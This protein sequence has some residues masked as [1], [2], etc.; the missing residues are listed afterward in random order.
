M[1]RKKVFG[2]ILLLIT[3]FF[4]GLFGAYTFEKIY[5]KEKIIEVPVYQGYTSEIAEKSAPREINGDFVEASKKSSPA[6]VFI[7][8]IQ[9]GGRN[10]YYSSD[11]FFNF[12]FGDPGPRTSA[13]SGVIIS[14]D[15]YII[16][17]NHVIDEADK[18]EV[19]V[20]NFKKNYKATVIGKDA[21]S[22]LALLKIEADNLPYIEFGNSDAL[23]V[24]EWV[25]AVGNPF[26]LTSTVTSGIVSAKGRNINILQ[27][28][29]P[30]ESFIQT[31][32]A[33]NPGNSGGALVNLQGELVGINTAIL[34]KTGSYSGYGFAIPSN[35]VK[36]I[37]E[38]FKKYGIIQRA[39][40][41]A[42]IIDIDEQ[43]AEKLG[44]YQ[45]SGAYVNKVNE[46]GNAE[47]GG[48]EKGDVVLRVNSVNV[49]NRGLLDEQIAY[50]RPGDKIK[51]EVLRNDKVEE[52]TI[53][54][55]NTEGTTK[56]VK[57]T[58]LYSESLGASFKPLTKMDK[59]YYGI[60]YGVKVTEVK[61]G[62]LQTMGIQNDFIILTVNDQKFS[63]AEE[64]IEVLEN[65]KGWVVI[66][67]I[68]P[69]G[70]IVTR[71]LRVR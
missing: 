61:R 51:L 17:N 6:V 1:V 20:N 59:E 57:N 9:E 44:D 46:G 25:V 16:T 33:I 70:W 24:G 52:V 42:D 21:S 35:I 29:F 43:L 31:D 50:Y 37:I 47:K 8:A 66:K 10:N 22:D 30:I 58:N 55:T 48:L 19:V 62:L 71:T 69:E 49:K 38:D 26:N 41:Q 5:T 12:F 18:I 11:M 63:E 64:I 53:I 32:A 3:V 27:N 13:G 67:G 45:I 15:G 56:E 54:L 68:T 34:S 23:E 65:I 4:V 28:N 40:I 36:K 60:T 2:V 7:K 39:F 14:K